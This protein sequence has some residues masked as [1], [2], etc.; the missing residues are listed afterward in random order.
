MRD[1]KSSLALGPAFGLGLF[2][3]ER[4]IVARVHLR[5]M[6]GGEGL[7]G[8]LAATALLYLIFGALLGALA[9][10]L[11]PVRRRPWLIPH[12]AT[13]TVI[14]LT[15]A[16]LPNWYGTLLTAAAAGLGTHLLWLP[17]RRWPVAALPALTVVGTLAA[18]LCVIRP[19]GVPMSMSASPIQAATEGAPDIA[20]VVLDT[21]RRDRVSAYGGPHPTTPAFDRVAAEGALIEGAFVSSPWS[22]PSHA[23]LFTGLSP[24]NHGAH[25]E[26]PLLDPGF[27][28]LAAILARHGYRTVGVSANPWITQQ[29][30]S[31]RGFDEWH[32]T[33]PVHDV[34]RCFV[35]RWLIADRLLRT[36]GGDR[37]IQ[38]TE[39]LLSRDDERPVF[40][41][42]NVFEAHSPYDAVPAGCGQAF[43]PPDT[44]PRTVRRLADRLEL[45]Q[46][47]GA[48]YLPEGEERELTLALYDGAVL[49]ADQILEQVLE[50]LADRDR[51][52]VT[53]VLAD[54]GESLGEHGEVGHHFGLYDLLI[55]VPMAVSY[56]G[57]IPPGHRVAGPVRGV[58]LLPTLLDYAGV[59]PAPAGEGFSVRGALAGRG[60]PGMSQR[61]AF[62]EHYTPVF[63]LEAFRLARPAGRYD[64]VDRRRRAL[65]SGRYRYEEDS[66]GE[67]R[68]YDRVRDPAEEYDLLVTGELPPAMPSILDRMT[69]R[70]AW[71]GGPW[72]GPGANSTDT[73]LDERTLEYLRELGYVP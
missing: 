60:D 19:A 13:G 58:D 49:C 14:A 20:L 1:L 29:N 9:L 17:V 63:V 23:T 7:T 16:I 6:P 73:G 36:K 47:A 12:L 4:C 8:W 24:G 54:H 64:Q 38:V 39:T 44:S 22:L 71:R 33:A 30:G 46:T 59:S 21:V 42:V 10:A 68:L 67:R 27:P 18:V 70:D 15:V 51:P 55:R 65:F 34:A 66:R 48:G 41:F 43:L 31:A 28:T 72:Q 11:P 45:A 3:A 57:E 37:T 53:V 56:P 32:D 35:L 50:V 5:A 69:A 26:H 40:L 61:A 2:V 62:A 52:R 25:Y